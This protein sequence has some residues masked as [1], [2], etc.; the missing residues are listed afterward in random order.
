MTARAAVRLSWESCCG[1]RA[2]AL[3]SA[4]EGKTSQTQ[5]ATTS[6]S[7]NSMPFLTSSSSSA[8]SS[9]GSASTTGMDSVTGTSGT[10]T[11]DKSTKTS[12]TSIDPALPPGGIEMITPAAAVAASQYFKIGDYVTLAWNYTSLSVT[13]SAIDVMASCSVN[14]Q[15]YTIALNQSVSPTGAV[16]W[17]T[18]GYQQTA[19]IPLLTE[20]YTLVIYDAAE[21]VSATPKAGYLGTSDQFTFGMYIPQAYSPLNGKWYCASS[22]SQHG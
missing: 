17:D 2:K 3:S 10:K 9:S 5:T 16:T 18:G 13:P 6:P 19:T 14:N 11:T 8:G 15:L 4:S 1:M 21:S 7:S 22:E 20:T 12:S